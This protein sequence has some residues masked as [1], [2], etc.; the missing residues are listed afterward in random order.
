[1]KTTTIKQTTKSER[2]FL[3]LLIFVVTTISLRYALPIVN[4]QTVREVCLGACEIDKDNCIRNCPDDPNTIGAIVCRLICN[5][6]Y[7]NCKA[8][9][10]A[11]AEFTIINPF[12]KGQND[13]IENPFVKFYHDC[14][15]Q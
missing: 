15:P 11:E 5:T 12:L 13:A 1:M 10:P 4:G 7:T 6:N 8:Q 2:F 3:I 14:Q 9:C